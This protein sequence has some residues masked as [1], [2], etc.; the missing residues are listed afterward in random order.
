MWES[1]KADLSGLTMAR[2]GHVVV[3]DVEIPF[4]RSVWVLLRL[5]AAAT[6]AAAALWLLW[7]FWTLLF[8]ILLVAAGQALSRP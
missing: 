3:T 5:G 2:P 1:D 4:W 7:L 8:R 6:L